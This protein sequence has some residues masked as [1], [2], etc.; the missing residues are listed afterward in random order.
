MQV[1]Q[2][3][4]ISRN[5]LKKE[6]LVLNRKLRAATRQYLDEHPWLWAECVNPTY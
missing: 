5:P 6:D 1:G 3:E 4:P 2:W